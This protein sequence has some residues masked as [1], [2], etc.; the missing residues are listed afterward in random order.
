MAAETGSNP[1]SCRIENYRPN[2][3]IRHRQRYPALS[4]KF[5]TITQQVEQH[6]AQPLLVGPDITGHILGAGD[7][8]VQSLGSSPGIYHIFDNS[9]GVIS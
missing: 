3:P 1:G 2:P 9:E 7:S 6:L 4:G 5:D 8:A